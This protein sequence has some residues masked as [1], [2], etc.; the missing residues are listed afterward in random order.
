MTLLSALRKAEGSFLA[1]DRMRSLR[2]SR[3]MAR[4][5]TRSWIAHRR[6]PPLP[7]AATVP[8]DAASDVLLL[9]S[10]SPWEFTPQ[11]YAQE[12]AFAHEMAA[13]GRPFAVT[14]KPA[15]ISGKSVVWFLPNQFVSPRLWDYSKQVREFAVGIEQQGNRLFCSSAETAF[16]ENKVHMHRRLDEVDAP[17][18]ETRILTADSWKSIEFDIEPVLIKL[19]HS[20]GSEGIYH[21]DTAGEARS[22]V[23]DYAFR[24]T[25][26]LIM[27]ELVKGATRDL[28]VTLVG[29]RLIES[30]TYWRTKSAEAL[31][32]S[33]WT[34]TA[35]TFNSL[36][37]HSGIPD[38]VLPFVVRYMSKLGIRTAGIDLMWID[39]DLSRDPLI[40]EFSP[41]YQPNPPKPAR[42]HDV[43]YKQ[44]KTN[45]A[46]KGGYLESQYHVFREIAGQM[47]DQELF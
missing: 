25:E 20:A 34:T 36:V 3:S 37:D 5:L 26:S 7:R 8:L 43:S 47:I 44:F 21:F 32:K 16:W 1:G 13:R 42:Y 41:Y 31:S 30:A 24:P 9:C 18:P 45:W 39:D 38:S 12:S 14:D 15:E 17:T 2:M 4:L 46:A 29:E 6:I 35:T 28:R 40:L 33:E 11:A 22:F 23:A 10:W 27:Q 19:E